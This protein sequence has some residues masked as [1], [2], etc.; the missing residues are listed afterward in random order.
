MSITTLIFI[1]QLIFPRFFLASLPDSIQPNS[2][3]DIY[4]Y[5]F[6]NFNLAS[7]YFSY[8]NFLMDYNAERELFLQFTVNAI[9]L[10]ATQTVLGVATLYK[11]QVTGIS[12]GSPMTRLLA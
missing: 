1:T 12:L 5:Q 10:S 2:S 6:F 8:S 3:I 4:N 7:H 11:V 9:S